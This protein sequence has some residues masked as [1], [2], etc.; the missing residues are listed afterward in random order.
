MTVGGCRAT[1][2]RVLLTLF[3]STLY[4][5]S[6]TCLAD[7][8][9]DNIKNLSLAAAKSDSFIMNRSHCG[10]RPWLIGSDCHCA[11]SLDGI[12]YCDSSG[13]PGEVHVF[14]CPC[15]ARRKWLED[16]PIHT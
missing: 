13:E 15:M 11:D 8:L 6:T 7:G 16:V 10:D 1:G 9:S 4:C 14:A 2:L 5:N 12:I 3:L